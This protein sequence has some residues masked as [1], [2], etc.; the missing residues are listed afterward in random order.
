LIVERVSKRFAGLL[1]LDG[2]SI[3]VDQ[4]EIVG[5]IGP[6]G[7]G[8]TTLINVVTG[9]MP[10]SDGRIEVDGVDITGRPAHRIARIGV[11]RTFQRVRLFSDLTVLENVKVAAVGVGRRGRQARHEARV[12]L[13]ELGLAA[14][15]ERLAGELPYGLERRVEVAR[16]LATSPKYLLLDEPAAGLDEGESDDLL[17]TLAPIPA[18]R[19]LGILIIDHDMSLIMRLC[20][21][22]HV[23][24]YGKTIGAGTPDQVRNIPE[25]V[26]A[27]LGATT[28]A[29]AD[30]DH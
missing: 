29:T 2:V 1:A 14:W 23:L 22:L 18:D 28:E 27:Y 12:L 15:S 4:G 8:K 13:D 11:A 19:G 20:N 21:R 25:V 16:A 30:A 3:R 5:L 26:A 9:H 24:N 7:S 10:P 17:R 6:N